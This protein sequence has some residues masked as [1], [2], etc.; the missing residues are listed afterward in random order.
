MTSKKKE[1]QE[2]ETKK[3]SN[4]DTAKTVELKPETETPK[5]SDDDLS[6]EQ[7][8]YA[9]IQ[10][11]K[12]WKEQ[13]ELCKFAEILD[14]DADDDFIE[15]AKKEFND[16]I[17]SV[18]EMKFPITDSEHVNQRQE[19]CELI[20]D[21]NYRF[22]QWKNGEWRGVLSLDRLMNKII[23]ELKDNPIEKPVELDF[24]SIMFLKQTFTSP[25]GIGVED[26]RWLAQHE[27]YDE[28]KQEL[29]PEAAESVTYSGVLRM[30]NKHVHR[31]ESENKRLNIY[32][33]RLQLAYAGLRM[34]LNITDL[35]EFVAFNDAL[36][37]AGLPQNGEEI[38]NAT[39]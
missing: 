16:A 29:K 21:Y 1:E 13:K 35:E 14:Q 10:F 4:K 7:I 38:V 32:R 17:E 3:R 31:I 33:N 30:I 23:G 15:E 8:E 18:R 9:R 12:N 5:N 22:N 24:S 19:I 39:K 20:R 36:I 34:K 37:S 6:D 28:E 11:R 26:A 2:L 25:T 27:C